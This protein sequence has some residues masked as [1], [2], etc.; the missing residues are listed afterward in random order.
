MEEIE[1][2]PEIHNLDSFNYKLSDEFKEYARYLKLSYLN[3]RR[4]IEKEE[5]PELEYLIK[6]NSYASK[7]EQARVQLKSGDMTEDEYFEIYNAMKK[8]LMDA[9]VKANEE[10][11]K[12]QE[13][14]IEEEDLEIPEELYNYARFRKL[15]ILKKQDLLSPEGAA[16]LEHIINTNEYAQTYLKA[17]E[18]YEKHKMSLIAFNA[19]KDR[20]SQMLMEANKVVTERRRKLNTIS[21]PEE[22]KKDKPKEI[23]EEDELNKLEQDI[24]D[25][26]NEKTTENVQG[27]K[28]DNEINPIKR[29]PVVD[30]IYK[31]FSDDNKSNGEK[32]TSQEDIKGKEKEIREL[33]RYFNLRKKRNEG[34]TPEEQKEYD[35]IICNND[36][37]FEVEKADLAFKYNKISKDEYNE[38]IN[39]QKDYLIDALYELSIIKK[40]EKELV[41]EEVKE[42]TPEEKVNVTEEDSTEE[43]HELNKDDNDDMLKLMRQTVDHYMAYKKGLNKIGVSDMSELLEMLASNSKKEGESGPALMK[44]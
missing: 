44:K 38:I 35:E 17:K 22:T 12:E 2:K 6:N 4:L 7:V 42:N 32:E 37:A 3:E 26:G 34:L 8:K 19:V 41:T 18:M 20:L 24:L 29:D 5:I 40:E 16:E 39:A 33:H 36:R 21:K 43:E 27:T 25:Y 11:E 13:E 28:K 15:S 14:T 1:Y 31:L 10:R 30:F 23:T 9:I